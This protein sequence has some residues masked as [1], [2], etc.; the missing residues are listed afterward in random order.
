MGGARATDHFGPYLLSLVV[1]WFLEY[2]TQFGIEI[3][4]LSLQA[5]KPVEMVRAA[6]GV[7]DLLLGYVEPGGDLLKR[8][9]YAVAE[10]GKCNG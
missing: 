10:T 7:V 1:F 9:L 4:T 5:E 6:T 3:L 2:R 8:G